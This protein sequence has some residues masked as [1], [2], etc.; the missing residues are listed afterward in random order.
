MEFAGCQ[1]I[2][3]A[4]WLSDTCAFYSDTSAEVPVTDSEVVSLASERMIQM[5]Q[6][7]I[8]A[9]LTLGSVLIGF[10][11][12]TATRNYER[13]RQELREHKSDLDTKLRDACRVMKR[14]SVHCVMRRRDSLANRGIEQP[15]C[16]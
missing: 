6:W 2:V 4:Y 11:W 10:N 8:G 3:P 5:A 13:D 1:L 16:M 15:S 14:T 12:I 9:V 7:T